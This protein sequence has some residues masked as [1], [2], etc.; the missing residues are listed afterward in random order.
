M[1]ILNDADRQ[2]LAAAPV[3]PTI[4]VAPAITTQGTPVEQCYAAM[5]HVDKHHAR[6]VEN[7][8]SIARPGDPLAPFTNEGWAERLRSFDATPAAKAVGEHM[9]AVDRYVADAEADAARI[10]DALRP[11]DDV[12]AQVKAQRDWSRTKGSLDA[13]DDGTVL[14]A[15]RNAIRNA[16]DTELPTVAEEIRPYLD[17]RGVPGDWLDDALGQRVPEYG[18]ARDRVRVAHKQRAVLA[19]DAAKLHK[20]IHEG[21]RSEVPLV[22][23]RNVTAQRYA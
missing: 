21:R 12:A 1:G 10:R 23:P 5:V 8:N 7:V 4:P 18:Q 2:P 3:D 13:A 16:T 20:Q 11:G 15:A 22:D 9:Q 6:H 14:S 17:A 19:H